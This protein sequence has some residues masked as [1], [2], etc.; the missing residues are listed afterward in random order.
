METSAQ[1]FTTTF[2]ER[3]VN[4]NVL[5][6]YEQKTGSADIIWK[7]QYLYGSS[8]LGVWKPNMKLGSTTTKDALWTAAN[9]RE[10]EI[11][12]HLGNVL[13][14]ITDNKTPTGSVYDVTLSSAVD[15][16]PFGMQLVGRKMNGSSYRYGF[17][18]KENDNEVK[19]EGNQQ[20]YGMRIY[21]PRIGR[22][23]SED[24]LT[25]QFPHYTP[26]QFSGNTPIQAVDLDGS[27]ERHYTLL[28]NKS[29]QPYL[30]MTSEET[31]KHHSLFGYKWTTPIHAERADVNYNGTHYYIGYA[32]AK[33][34]GNQYG[35]GAFHEWAKNPD[36]AGLAQFNDETN[37]N[38]A[39]ATNASEGLMLSM[40][41]YGNLLPTKLNSGPP[42][43]VRSGVNSS[44]GSESLDLAPMNENRLLG[45]ELIVDENISPRVIQPLEEAG[46]SIKSFPKGTQDADIINYAKQG[47]SIVLT[48]NIKD[49]RNS[50]VTA[51][52]VTPKQQQN[53]STIVPLMKTLDTKVQANPS[54]LSPGK[55]VSLANPE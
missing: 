47:N 32:G 53:Y 6:T 3:D 40:W 37:S 48:N 30:K 45:R 4:G 5:A 51:I 14:T 2:Y 55:V 54:I 36:P 50:G 7:E 46:F 13:T 44:A 26:Y 49:F 29:G 9:N 1:N 8:R 41:T 19:G 42:S 52:K 25:K 20:D 21:D 11:T 33:G 15:Y 10:Y 38:W 35:I 23:L 24:P 27:E 39:A 43:P 22:F 12:N 18:G 31:V 17:N 16:S 28:F 34:T